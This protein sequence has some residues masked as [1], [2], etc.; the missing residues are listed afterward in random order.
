M[1]HCSEAKQGDW[2]LFQVDLGYTELFHCPA[3]TSVSFYTCEGFLG[4]SVV[5][6]NKSRLLTCLIG[7][8]SLLCTQFRV[9]G[10]HRSVRGRFMVFLELLREPGVHSRVTAGVAINNFCFLSKVRTPL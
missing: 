2:S 8:K 7:N 9:I 1:G 10:P 6:S 4:D 3:V 5:P